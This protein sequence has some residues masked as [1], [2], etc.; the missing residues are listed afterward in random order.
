M[1]KFLKI[2]DKHSNDNRI[3]PSFYHKKAFK[4]E[5]FVSKNIYYKV[6]MF[7][8]IGFRVII[9]D[10]GLRFDLGNSHIIEFYYDKTK[11]HLNVLKDKILI[12]GSNKVEVGNLA[13]F[14]K[15]IKK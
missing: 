12:S 1:V 2:Y 6:L 11:F 4:K 9:I 5:S 15:K 3:K 10:N 7:H 13:S 8:G 14:I